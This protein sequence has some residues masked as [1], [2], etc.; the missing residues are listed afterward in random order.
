MTTTTSSSKLSRFVGFY[1]STFRRGIGYFSLFS[2]LIFVFYPAQF[3]MEIFRISNKFLIENLTE[4]VPQISHYNLFGAAHSFTTASTFFLPLI[5]LLMPMILSL[6]L[7]SYMHSKKAADV[8]HALPI[9]RETL[10]LV[11]LAVS[12]TYVAIPLIC[13]QAAIALMGIVRFH[14]LDLS[15]L[16]WLMLD[17]LVWM[18]GAFVIYVITTF[19]SI[20]VGTVFDSFTFSCVLLS[21]PVILHGL[22]YLLCEMFLF[23]FSVDTDRLFNLLL[24]SPVS[25]VL[26]FFVVHGVNGISLNDESMRWIARCDSSILIWT[27]IGVAICLL[28]LRLY[29]NRRSET[30]ESTTSKGFL[31]IVVKLV[32]TWI[33]SVCCGLMFYGILNSDSRL[34]YFIW[35]AIGGLL[36]YNIIE[37]V[38]NRGFKTILRSLPFGIAVVA[39]I[40]LISAIPMTGGFGYEKRT[41]ALDQIA[42]VDISYSGRYEKNTLKVKRVYDDGQGRSHTDNEYYSGVTLTS[43]QDLEAVAAFHQMLVQQNLRSLDENAVWFYN[44]ITYTLKN[45]RTITRRYDCASSEAIDLLAPLEISPDVLQQTHPA[46]FMDG[47]QISSWALYDP[48]GYSYQQLVL[49]PAL[50]QKLFD[51]MQEDLLAETMDSLLYPTHHPIAILSFDFLPPT[52]PIERY[53]YNGYFYVLEGSRTAQVLKELNLLDDLTVD[54]SKCTGAVISSYPLYRRSS[55]GAVSQVF[56]FAY[57]RDE[58]P[59]EQR[60][61]SILEQLEYAKRHASSEDLQEEFGEV[62]TM[63]TVATVDSVFTENPAEIRQLASETV[64]TYHRTE[65]R[66]YVTFFFEGN[67]EAL[68][69]NLSYLTSC[70]VPREKLP[71]NLSEFLQLN[72]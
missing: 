51:A 47:N 48:Y 52:E 61:Q 24:L 13:S 68:H 6:V 25:A 31:Q 57:T 23:G 11:N 10:L 7:N 37:A 20:L 65:E 53:S 14:T 19:T 42:S 5:I 63:N 8:Y 15:I 9:R 62:T 36:A 49:S 69:G 58:V 32:A 17:T 71:E 64:A 16:K 35:A 43:S 46:F 40:L 56:N 44:T 12:M 50:S 38:L 54:W 41:P 59:F 1:K 30:A 60:K 27:A 66:T 72:Y 29:R 55:E 45:G 22:F 39:A 34:I 26:T 2:A 3:G 70:L 4:Y 21:A 18:I 28:T 33:V 67:E